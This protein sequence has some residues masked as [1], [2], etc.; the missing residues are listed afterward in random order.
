MITKTKPSYIQT[1]NITSKMDKYTTSK[2][3]KSKMII[4]NDNIQQC[5]NKS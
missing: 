3:D 2:N 1:G 5:C 4:D